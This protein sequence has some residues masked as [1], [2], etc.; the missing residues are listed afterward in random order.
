MRTENALI[1]LILTLLATAPLIHAA[2]TATTL[3][4][5]RVPTTRSLNVAYTNPCTA[6]NFF[7]NEVDANYDPDIDGNAS[8]V[9]PAGIRNLG[10]YITTDYNYVGVTNPSDYNKAFSGFAAGLPPSNNNNPATELPDA[11]YTRISTENGVLDYAIGNVVSRP[12]SFRFL[13]KT[14]LHPGSMRDMNF[15]FV[16]QGKKGNSCVSDQGLDSDVNGYIW[17]Y[18][19]SAYERLFTHDAISVISETD[20]APFSTEAIIDYN[21]TDYISSDQN[22]LILVQGQDP[23]G[24]NMECLSTDFAEL[25]ITHTTTHTSFCQHETIAPIA[26]T[27]NG[28]VD[29]N[30]D[31]NFATAFA[32]VDVNVVLKVWLGTGSGCGDSGYGGWEATCSATSTTNP[33]TQ[34]Q[35]K[36]FNEHNETTA[37]RLITKLIVGDTNQLCF[38]GDFNTWVS[39]GDHNQN[40]QVGV[41]YS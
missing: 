25:A 21:F 31:G 37:S 9:R 13:F 40:F 23:D 29:V 28:N 14:S 4:T 18:R 36:N 8:K 12:A 32:G 7:F 10:T 24:T 41:L 30:V 22:V 6:T 3:F 35:C 26:L 5:F 27:N 15:T 16:G 33:I 11:N 1:L 20:P 39:A 17:N 38:S 19:T 2:T 34:T